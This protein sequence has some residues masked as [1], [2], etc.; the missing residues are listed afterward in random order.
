MTL[1]LLDA[2]VLIR[3]HED[4]Y[5][6]DRIPPFWTWLLDQA[7][8]NVIKMPRDIFDEVTPP[9]GPFAAWLAQK[10]VREALILDESIS[11]SVIRRVLDV[12]YAP[13]LTDVQID[14]IGKDPFL[15]ASALGGTDR[16]VVTVE[17]SK[18]SKQRQNRKVP[19][20]CQRLGIKSINP[21]ELYRLLNFSIP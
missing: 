13:D 10:T 12:G 21:F 14:A 20:V 8:S 5:P 16:V 9:P 2:N 15:V 1:Y 11:V 19:D 3:A 7:H 6:V 17:V 18:P 4:Y